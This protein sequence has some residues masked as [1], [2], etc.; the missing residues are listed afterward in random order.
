[1]SGRFEEMAG[2]GRGGGGQE[3]SV[4]REGLVAAQLTEFWNDS[5]QSLQDLASSPGTH[6]PSLL[7]GIKIRANAG[8]KSSILLKISRNENT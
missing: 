7:D 1:M 5:R 8:A 2:P 4:H 6:L 3:R